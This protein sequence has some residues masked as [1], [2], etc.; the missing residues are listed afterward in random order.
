M[1]SPT[2]RHSQNNGRL[3]YGRAL[4]QARDE[5]HWLNS[6]AK[7]QSFRAP[8]KP[9]QTSQPAQIPGTTDSRE[10]GAYPRPP[11][12]EPLLAVPPILAFETACEEIRKRNET[13][14]LILQE[15][16]QRSESAQ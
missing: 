14:T 9:L 13:K 1:K 6:M 16:L 11:S 7:I 5:A 15:V 3:E 8:W 12:G 10:E 2:K 4:A